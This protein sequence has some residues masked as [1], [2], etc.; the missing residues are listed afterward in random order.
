MYVDFAPLVC[1]RSVSETENRGG[2]TCFG[3]WS[4]VAVG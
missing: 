1:K 4:K 2:V 3:L